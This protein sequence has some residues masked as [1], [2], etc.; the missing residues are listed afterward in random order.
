MEIMGEEVNRIEKDVQRLSGKG[1]SQGMHTTKG[2]ALTPVS[3]RRGKLN[4]NWER[5]MRANI[6]QRKRGREEENLFR[7]GGGV[8]GLT[9]NTPNKR[10][11]VR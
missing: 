3:T 8:G 4:V 10:R 5:E 11:F 1:N 7:D 2:G 6:A 9:P